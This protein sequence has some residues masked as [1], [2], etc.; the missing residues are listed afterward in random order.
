MNN[1]LFQGKI[2]D[3]RQ[4]WEWIKTALSSLSFKEDNILI[5]AYIKKSI[6]VEIADQIRQARL[7]EYESMRKSF[8][9]QGFE[10]LPRMRPLQ[11]VKV[12]ARWNLMDLVGGAS[13]IDAYRFAKDQ[14]WDFY[15]DMNLH[16]KI[17]SFPSSGILLG[18]ANATNSGL[19]LSSTSNNEGGTVVEPNQDNLNFIDNMFKQA[20]KLDDELFSK[21][22][23][24]YDACDKKKQIIEWPNELLDDITP[25][26]LSESKLLIDE[27]LHS[28]GHEILT[29]GQAMDDSSLHDLSLLGIPLNVF[30]REFIISKFL[31]SK[32]F[33]FTLSV[34][35]EN[36]GVL[37]YGALTQA[38]HNALV[39][40]PMPYRSEIK[41]KIISS[42]YSWIKLI[43]PEVSKIKYERPNHSELLVLVD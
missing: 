10:V 5:S 4:S 3:G 18:S 43:G 29:H 38:V 16:A 30:D 31:R 2:I 12:L 41:E 28:D 25:N 20:V 19:G 6:L 40:D 36:N 7:E 14:G 23:H 17:Y 22:Q 9:S 13:D 1:Y 33:L 32:I 35:K 21:I 24:A 34:L 27:C 39:E 8:A 42:I 15:I 26:I 37:R 11:R